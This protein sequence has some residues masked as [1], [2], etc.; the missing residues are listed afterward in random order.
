M[1][2]VSADQTL[3]PYRHIWQKSS[4]KSS[5]RGG[6]RQ[7]L[8]FVLERLLSRGSEALSKRHRMGSWRR[9]LVTLAA[10]RNYPLISPWVKEMG[11]QWR[12]RQTGETNTT[13]Q[14]AIH[15][16]QKKSKF[17]KRPSLTWSLKLASPALSQTMFP[18]VLSILATFALFQILLLGIFFSIERLL[19]V[20]F[21]L[22]SLLFP[23]FSL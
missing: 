21:I 19:P 11:T 22:N 23:P 9:W 12:K 16:S 8:S 20:L 10:E 14:M 5:S 17:L 2:Q 3:K 1:M 6:Q 18:F 15:W 4:I 7:Q 13:L